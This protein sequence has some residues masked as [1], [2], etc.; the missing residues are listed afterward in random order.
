MSSE[1]D[2]DAEKCGICMDKINNEDTGV[3][4]CGHIF[5]HKC[6]CQSI[7]TNPHCPYCKHKITN[8]D[9]FIMSFERHA[10]K[11]EEN[12][13]DL[14]K[15]DL[16]NDVG[17]KIGNLI[18]FLRESRE[19]T[20]LFSQ[21]DDLLEKTSTI[22]ESHGIRNMLCKGSLWQK[23][24]AMRDFNSNDNVRVICLSSKRSASG[25]NLQ[26]ATQII[27]LDPIYGSAKYRKEQEKQ[28][29]GR[30]H[31]MG[32]TKTIKIFRFIIKNSVE[33]EIFNINAHNDE[34]QIDVTQ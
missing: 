21:W 15:T 11:V 8:K 1:S 19:H 18:L 10:D 27:F 16:I 6:I 29:I 28:A 32:Q 25:S 22:L 33:E 5:C 14:S 17:T 31:R 34:L 7:R 24:K 12:K 13:S 30:A 2:D 4:I 20:V 3:T 9:V 23:D 26:K